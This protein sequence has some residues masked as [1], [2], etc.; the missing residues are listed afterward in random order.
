MNHLF[1]LMVQS[2]KNDWHM[3]RTPGDRIKLA[4]EILANVFTAAR[5]GEFVE[6]SARVR[7]GRGLHYRDVVF[8]I[9]KNEQGEPE[10]AMQ[11]EK[12]AK[13]T[14]DTPDKR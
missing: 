6:S 2:W 14:T 1:H 9:F 7:S 8:G 3:F 5:A 10:F 11:V 13:G 4:G 12:D